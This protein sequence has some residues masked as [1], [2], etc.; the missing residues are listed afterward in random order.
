MSQK[1]SAKGLTIDGVEIAPGVVETIISLAAGE[2]DGV[3]GVGTAGT[4]SS[5]VS[6]FNAGR[7]IPT[8]GIEVTVGDDNRISVAITIQ[9]YYGHR[10]VDVAERVRNAV[11]D[12]LKGQTGAEVAAV[13]VYVDGL[14]FEE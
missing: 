13:D 2:V 9:A 5:I 6:A 7:A 14:A 11:A 1:D 10:I 12:A 8:T 4:I 3:A